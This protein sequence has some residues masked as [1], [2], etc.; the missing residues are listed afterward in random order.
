[1]LVTYR[2][3][4]SPAAAIFSFLILNGLTLNRAHALTMKLFVTSG[5][6]NV[7]DASSTAPDAL[8]PSAHPRIA[9]EMTADI[10]APRRATAST[11]KG[12]ADKHADAANISESVTLWRRKYLFGDWGGRRTAL[13][14]KGLT[15]DFY[16]TDDALGNPIGGRSDFALWGR[17]RG[18]MDVDFSKFTDWQGL[19][20]HATGLWQYGADLSKQY[21]FTA[22]DSS[23]LP[24]AHTLRLDSYFLQQYM[25]HHK[26]AFRGG[27]IAAY[28]SYGDSEYG[29]SFINLALGY[30]H[31]NLNAA[32]Y[33]SFNP[34]GVPA[35]EVK[36][37]PTD[38]FYV[39]AMVLSEERNPYVT[40]TNGFDFH[41]GGP[42]LATE[43]GYMVDPPKA[44][45]ASYTMGV[46]PFITDK[47]TGNHL[48]I[49]RFGAGYDPHNFT[50]LLTNTDK[51]G[52][53]VLYAQAD[54]AVYRMGNM[55]SDRSRGLD[56]SYSEDYAPGDVTQYSHQIWVG[57]RWIGPAG[58]R[59]AKDAIGLGYVRTAVGSHYRELMFEASGKELSSE[60]LVE[61]NYLAHLTPWLLVQPVVQ[62][63]VKPAGDASREDVVVVGFRTKVT[64]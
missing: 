11:R 17:I 21:T 31:S 56:L 13:E 64:F 62:L 7:P 6:V 12:G 1:M 49:Y 48:G 52:N 54:Q 32:A 26:L 33:L 14:K 63:Y 50:D 37:L 40:D 20:F 44:P 4:R 9:E 45:N 36:V 57:A 47:K 41:L 2:F 29:A 39:K 27:Q 60:H 38:N 5:T 46:E 24:S 23:S 58:G 30:A 55:G 25:L 15:F 51:A 3:F 34:A 22:V 35:F 43:A 53:Y 59:W 61:A 18:S 8:V 16:Y 28:D 10:T 19:T 42:V